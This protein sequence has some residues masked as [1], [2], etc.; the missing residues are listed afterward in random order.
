MIS[1]SKTSD[2]FNL[3]NEKLKE[4]FGNDKVSE[5]DLIGINGIEQTHIVKEICQIDT[6]NNKDLQDIL[7]KHN[8]NFKIVIWIFKYK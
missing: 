5:C 2:I 6:I 3:A 4:I 8:I 7:E 1:S